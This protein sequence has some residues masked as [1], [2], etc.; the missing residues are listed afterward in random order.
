MIAC[1][2]DD[3]TREII[4]TRLIRMLAGVDSTITRIQAAAVV[5]IIICSVTIRLEIADIEA[6]RIIDRFHAKQW[7]G[8]VTATVCSFV[9][10]WKQRLGELH[11]TMD[12]AA[13]LSL[14]TGDTE[15]S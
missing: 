8:R 14:A 5:D 11:Q 12:S 15:V 9:K 7:S 6:L 2:H 4:S 10:P 1:R 13:K 3:A